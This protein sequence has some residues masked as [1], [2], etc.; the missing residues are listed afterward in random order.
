MTEHDDQLDEVSSSVE[1]ISVDG[2]T[3]ACELSR[4]AGG[5]GGSGGGEDLAPVV[6]LHGLT[7][8]TARAGESGLDMTGQLAERRVL[9]CD[10]RAHGASTGRPVAADHTWPRLAEDLLTVLETML[11]GEAVHAVGPS[12]GA[13]TLLHA[14]LTE[15]E[16]FASLTLLIPPTAWE[17]RAAQAEQYRRTAAVVESR[18]IDSFVRARAQAEAPPAL[19]GRPRREEPAVPAEL[20]GSVLRGAADSDLPDPERIAALEIP[21]L[22]L[23]WTEDPA[24]PVATAERLHELLEGS[25]L[26]VAATPEQLDAWPA[27]AAEHAAAHE[28]AARP[29]SSASGGPRAAGRVLHS[30]SGAGAA[31]R[32]G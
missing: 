32:R 10:A 20:L 3:L 18:G 5:D 14:A 24:H 28:P 9:R 8:C 27:R 31:S 16:R 22:L 12:M 30:P 29:S 26:A 15:P 11:P 25:R 13:A 17:T 23:A 7:S 6:Q 2:A 1:T 19:A 4:P 21:T